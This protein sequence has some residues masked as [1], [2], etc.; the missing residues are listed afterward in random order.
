MNRGMPLPKAMQ[1]S[2]IFQRKIDAA[3]RW[4]FTQSVPLWL[5]HGIDRQRGGFYDA[6][7]QESLSNCADEK[8]LRVT[9]RQIYVF[10]EAA[11]RDVPGARAA[12]DHGL[13]FLFANL[14]H[15]E[16]GFVRSCDLDG[17]I[18]DE[19]RDLYDLAFTLFALA[20]ACRLG[21]AASLQAEALTLLAFIQTHMRHSAGGYIE[22]LPDRL[23]RRQNPHMHLLEAAL[24]CWEYMPHPAF[25]ALCIEIADLAACYFL[26]AE[27]GLLF[28]YYSPQLLPDRPDGRA[29]VEPGHHFEW[30]WL[31]AELERLIGLKLDGATALTAF[32][33]RHG[34]NSARQLLHGALYEDGAVAQSSVRLWPHAEWLR[35]TLVLDAAG[36]TDLAFASLMR[37]LS[38]PTPGLWFEHWDDE[39]GSFQGKSVPASSL[40]HIMSAFSALAGLQTR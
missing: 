16:G 1:Y 39:L 12:V 8:R 22:A 35:A 26:D 5:E 2:I 36:N 17:K 32:A 24:A 19:S 34:W 11:L 18:L 33:L 14:R 29:L 27:A 21:G 38:A 25:H 7:D 13:A 31:L 15:P 30:V 4:L 3:Q 6:L 20:H 40:Y 23:P 37:F 28:E 10:T 9:A